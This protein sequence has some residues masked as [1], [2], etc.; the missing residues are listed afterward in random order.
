MRHEY[1]PIN[2]EIGGQIRMRREAIRLSRDAFSERVG[3]T[4]RFIAD[5]ECGRVGVSL[6]TLRKVCEVLGASA[7][8]ILWSD[9]ATAQSSAERLAIML[10]GVSPQLLPALEKSIRDQIALLDMAQ[11]SPPIS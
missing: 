6:T 5:I 11:N 4:P 10:S 2:I 9:R 1:K 7:D 8:D 3:V